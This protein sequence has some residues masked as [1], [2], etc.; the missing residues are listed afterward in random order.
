MTEPVYVYALTALI[1]RSE[2]T[3]GIFPTEDDALTAFRQLLPEVMEE[4]GLRPTDVDTYT[5]QRW[6]L[7]H[8]TIPPFSATRMSLDHTGRIIQK[9]E[10][11]SARIKEHSDTSRGARLKRRFRM[12]EPVGIVED[13]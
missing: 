12:E 9:Y 1:D 10:L 4:L 2:Y 7:G 11:Y 8:F 5:L 13:K 6:S 3:L